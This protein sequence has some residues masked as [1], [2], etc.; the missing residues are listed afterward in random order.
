MRGEGR[1]LLVYSHPA[2]GS[3]IYVASAYS[4]LFLVRRYP[5]KPLNNTSSRAHQQQRPPQLR[6][7]SSGKEIVGVHHHL[8]VN[9]EAA[10]R[11]SECK[12]Q[13]SICTSPFPASN[14]Q[15]LHVATSGNIKASD[16]LARHPTSQNMFVKKLLCTKILC[17]KANT[18]SSPQHIQPNKSHEQEKQ[19]YSDPTA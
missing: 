14:V 3:S 13:N 9:I 6:R 12:S 7:F 1:G 2:L 17:S 19:L 4:L 5:L 8:D 11:Q 18:T 16:L 15:H 10:G